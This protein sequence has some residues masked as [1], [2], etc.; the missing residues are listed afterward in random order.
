[1][2]KVL[3]IANADISLGTLCSAVASAALGTSISL[4]SILWE[5][6]WTRVSTIARDYF[7]TYIT[8]TDSHQI[9]FSVLSSASLR[10]NLLVSVYTDLNIVLQICWAIAISPIVYIVLALDSW[11][12]YF[13][14]EGLTAQYLPLNVHRKWFHSISEVEFPVSDLVA[15]RI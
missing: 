10:I 9:W 8:T 1:M 4:V 15:R 2:R 13:G 3:N 12:Y 5:G 11:K 7:S 6:D 14:E